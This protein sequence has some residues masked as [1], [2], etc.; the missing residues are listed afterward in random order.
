M[1]KVH[2]IDKD[3]CKEI[4][5]VY[6]KNYIICLLNICVHSKVVSKVNKI[7]TLVLLGFLL[8]PFLTLG[9]FHPDSVLVPAACYNFVDNFEN[10]NGESGV[11]PL[12]PEDGT[13]TFIDA[14]ELCLSGNNKHY[15]MPPDAGLT[16]DNGTLL[17]PLDL[18]TVELLFR[19]ESLASDNQDDRLFIMNFFNQNGAGL[20]IDSDGIIKYFDQN[21]NI[22]AAGST[23]IPGYPD[24]LPSDWINIA[25]SL[26]NDT[27]TVYYD[28]NKEFE[29]VDNVFA[30]RNN[31]SYFYPPNKMRGNGKENP[32]GEIT[33]D[34]I[35]Y[36]GE[37]LDA[38]AIESL[39]LAAIAGNDIEIIA[40]ETAGCFGDQITLSATG[41]DRSYFIWSTGDTTETEVLNYTIFQTTDTIWVQGVAVSPCER[42][43]FDI[44]D[45]IVISGFPNPEMGIVGPTELCQGDPVTF[46]ASD[47][48]AGGQ[49]EYFWSTSGS[50]SSESGADTK[51]YSVI[52]SASGV[53]DLNLEIE[54]EYG[55]L[56]DTTIQI[57]VNNVPTSGVTAPA[58]ACEEQAVNIE[59]TGNATPTAIFTWDWD[60]GTVVNEN[61]PGRNFDIQWD[62][63]GTKTIIYQIEEGNCLVIDSITINITKKPTIEYI[64]PASVCAT[65]SVDIEYIGNADLAN[66]NLTWNFDG[67]VNSGDDV[68][69]QVVWDTPGTKS[70]SLSIDEGGCVNDSSFTLEVLPVPTTDLTAPTNVCSGLP[71]TFVYTGTADASAQLV[72]TLNGGTISTVRTENRDFDVTWPTTGIK[73]ITLSVNQNGCDTD[74]TFTVNVGKTPTASIIAPVGACANEPVIVSYLGNANLNLSSPNLVFDWD[75][76][77]DG[78][79]V[80]KMG[81]QE[82]YDVQ[83][84]TFGTKTI[85]LQVTENGCTS[86]LVSQ[87]IEVAEKPVISFNPPIVTSICI[88]ETVVFNFDGSA[89]ANGV[90]DWDFGDATQVN[91]TDANT[92][93]ELEWDSAGT[94]TVTLSITNDGCVTTETFEIDVLIPATTDVTYPDFACVGETTRFIYTGSGDT[95]D[96]GTTFDWTFED[97]TS[98]NDLGNQVYDVTWDNYDASNAANN[99]KTITL[100]INKNGCTV[101]ETFTVEISPI[102]VPEITAPALACLNETVTVEFDSNLDAATLS[103]PSFG[104]GATATVTANPEVWEVVWSTV[105]TKTISATYNL[106]GCDSTVTKTIQIVPIPSDDFDVETQICDNETANFSY[107]GNAAN[108]INWTVTPNTGVTITPISGNREIELGFPITGTTETYVVEAVVTNG[109]N[110]TVTMTENVTVLPAPIANI[111]IPTP[112]CSTDPITFDLSADYDS[113][114]SYR[115]EWDGGTV[116]NYNGTDSWTVSWDTAGVKNVELIVQSPNGCQVIDNETINVGYLPQLDELEVPAGV[117]VDSQFEIN[118]LGDANAVADFDWTIPADGSLVDN[119]TG[120]W[121]LEFGEPGNREI[122]L[123]MTG[124][125]GC[126][127]DTTFNI[128][129]D[130]YPEFELS[131]NMTCTD[132]EV[133]VDFPDELDSISWDFGVDAVFEQINDT[134]FSVSYESPGTKTIE[135]SI[136]GACGQQTQSD[137][138]NVSAGPEYSINAPEQACINDPDPYQVIL[139]EA[140]GTDVR[141][142]DYE[143]IPA[144]DNATVTIASNTRLEIEGWDYGGFKQVILEVTDESGSGCPVKY[145]TIDYAVYNFIQLDA[146]PNNG[147]IGDPI[148]IK[149]SGV[150]EDGATFV[151]DFAGAD[152]DTLVSNEEFELSWNTSGEKIINLD[153]QGNCNDV[154]GSISINIGEPANTALNFPT[155][156]CRGEAANITYDMSLLTTAS[157]VNSV[158]IIYQ[159]MP[160]DTTNDEPENGIFAPV[161]NTDGIKNFSL[162]VNNGG[163]IDTADYSL[164]VYEIPVANFTRSDNRVC[165]GEEVDFNFTGVLPAGTVV[166]WNFMEDDAADITENTVNTNYAVSW[167]TPGIKTI[168]LI[169]DNGGCI[170]STS[171]EVEVLPFPVFEIDLANEVCR[172]AP[173]V[174][175]LINNGTG[176]ISDFE[177]EW[178]F[179]N[180]TVVDLGSEE[181]ELTFPTA[182]TQTISVEILGEGGC[183]SAA[184]KNIE[185][186]PAPDLEYQTNPNP[187]CVQ[188]DYTFTY[189]GVAG[190]NFT[191]TINATVVNADGG[192]VTKVDNR[193][194]TINWDSAGFK[195]IRVSIE[196]DNG[197]PAIVRVNVEVL[198]RPAMTFDA[199]TTFCIGEEFIVSYTGDADPFTDSFTWAFDT[200]DLDYATKI[201]GQ[202]AYRVRYTAGGTRTIDVSVTTGNGCSNTESINVEL[203]QG[204]TDFTVEQVPVCAFDEIPFYLGG[205]TIVDI[206]PGQDGISD[207][208]NQN[209]LSWTTP[210]IKTIT[211]TLTNGNCEITE[212]FEL[213]VKP[214]PLGEI[215]VDIGCVGQPTLISY[216]GAGAASIFAEYDW[217]TSFAGATV[218]KLSGQEAYEVVWDTPGTYPISV[219]IIGE[220]DCENT[221]TLPGG[222]TINPSPVVNFSLPATICE[223]IEREIAVNNPDSAYQ[224]SWNIGADGVII[225]SNADSTIITAVWENI[226]DKTVSVS[227]SENGCTTV[228]QR[229]IRVLNAPDPSFDAPLFCI[230]EG[231]SQAIGTIFYTGDNN[232]NTDTFDWDFDID[233]TAG[234]SATQIAGTQN[235]EVVYTIPGRKDVSLTVTNDNCGSQTF[236]DIIAVNNLA[237]FDIVSANDENCAGAITQIR[238]TGVAEDGAIFNWDFDTD[239]NDVIN[240]IVADSLYEITY[241]STGPKKIILNITGSTCNNSSFEEEFTIAEPPTSDFDLGATENCLGEL[242][243]ITYTGTTS[244]GGV[245]NWDWADGIPTQLNDSTFEVR[246]PTPGTKEISLVVVDGGCISEVTRNSINVYD[247]ANPTISISSDLCINSEGTASIDTTNFE[248]GSKWSWDFQGVDFLRYENDSTLVNFSYNSAGEKSVRLKVEGSIC[249]E[250]D[251]TMII[252]VGERIPFSVSADTEIC[253]NDSARIVFTL[254]LVNGR[255]VEWDFDNPSQVTPLSNTREDYFVTWEEIG[256]KNITITINNK[257]C[258]RD[259]TFQV[260]VKQLPDATFQR[261]DYLCQDDVLMLVPDWDVSPFSI[262]SWDYVYNGIT[263]SQGEADF[264]LLLDQPGSIEITLSVLENGCQDTYTETIEIREKP[265]ASIDAPDFICLEGTANISFGDSLRAGVTYDWYFDGATTENDLGNEV[266]ELGWDVG[267]LKTLY[268]V[269]TLDGCPSD[270][271]FHNVNVFSLDNLMI[272]RDTICQHQTAIVEFEADG[273]G[274]ADDGYS[275]DFGTA[276]VIS[277][278]GFGPYELFWNTPGNKDVAI[279]IDGFICS[280]NQL[281]KTVTVEPSSFPGITISGPDLVCENIDVSLELNIENGGDAPEFEWFVNGEFIGNKF[282]STLIEDQDIVRAKLIS[283]AECVINSEVMSNEFVVNLLNYKYQGNTNAVPNPVCLG[284]SVVI[285]LDPGN[286]RILDWEI[287]DNMEDWQSLGTSQT[288]LVDFP[289]ADTYYRARIIDNQGL[290]PQTT[291]PATVSVVPFEPINAGNDITI[292]EGD[293][294]ILEATNGS[295]FIWRN[296][297]SIQS[298]VRNSRI[299]VSPVKTTTF[300]VDGLT[301]NGC[302][303]TD[304]VTVVVRPPIAP[305]NVFTPNGDGVNDFWD[306]G[307]IGE[308]PNPEVKIYNRWGKELFYSLGYDQPWD[309]KFNGEVLSPGVYYYVIDLNDGYEPV[310][311]TITILY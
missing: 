271:A 119:G 250:F 75:W 266:Y 303:D 142:T 149:F 152:V 275:W 42:Q 278:T 40:S 239:A 17:D 238:F 227:A 128:N 63:L 89:G 13:G 28:G 90:F 66:A 25:F 131:S 59:Y 209:L 93:F 141:I 305:A 67:G 220:N 234:E 223:F 45:T 61:D 310:T 293:T 47:D 96:A 193:T 95:N 7:S 38:T 2:S 186:S 159:N 260:E 198:P 284:D 183:N 214:T 107:K 14:E 288:E 12:I 295:S 23:P 161:W 9:Q 138:V 129:V 100:E 18:Y 19:I 8:S 261:D 194:S 300:I 130:F 125:A 87:T 280:T 245:L 199:P 97:A 286:Y 30:L 24:D 44:A 133:F 140:F 122:T 299:Q 204:P 101:I 37:A 5:S 108:T 226:G 256:T 257:G 46:S 196:D 242:T 86:T 231:S 306:L 235:Y 22:L 217:G 307:G 74:T 157:D 269:T 115:W 113:N 21:D 49:V 150:V 248:P 251:T 200:T 195:T 228:R 162:V 249:N 11:A 85:T 222:I 36:F 174:V 282:D 267:G 298:D 112:L 211:L 246:W 206:D 229:T 99:I 143:L 171:R 146:F 10:D 56:A 83:W 181:Y 105:G 155:E 292:R 132:I 57:T 121:L 50:T 76:G 94:K 102:P 156:V 287:S 111:P 145:E 241:N 20:F 274:I 191:G 6:R 54:N 139:A 52:Y 309:G 1:V 147:C 126:I 70:I 173:T 208:I 202:Q 253:S 264:E 290:C 60:G 218:T 31:T 106:N 225:N 163:C 180:A 296:D 216:G 285:S 73:N 189:T 177:F 98:V 27:L 168:N 232:L 254:P 233:T 212:E 35:R 110:C 178:N 64:A 104:L 127:V 123:E 182:S 308:Y 164:R 160:N 179:G 43:C 118:Y 91:V 81:G 184:S 32:E 213:E 172:N 120:S 39:N 262:I 219:D 166:D 259:S 281:V 51:D 34:Y 153:I 188:E 137:T 289:D 62:T 210:G 237:D 117:C 205:E 187:V 311:G 201:A 279:N 114:N 55:C 29:Y 48:P 144:D 244:D 109:N 148:N 240:E 230:D 136:F 176:T 167:Q 185:V 294:R 15:V 135:L 79:A 272:E 4:T 3:T 16:V 255:S 151:W 71:A 270:T 301:V 243:I 53:F 165:V 203:V 103:T 258:I 221:I 207:S 72:W 302:P 304:S 297:V 154:S 265:L 215:T 88:D 247:N 236:T 197:C 84:S 291:P 277:G 134:T 124:G 65:N 82:A 26:S 77:T 263:G 175:R 273:L 78:T 92:N 68:N 41:G 58:T 80:K 190:T 69:A 116:E 252:N 283:N 268:V 276:R 158:A 170:D 224:Y 33:V 169:L 192:I